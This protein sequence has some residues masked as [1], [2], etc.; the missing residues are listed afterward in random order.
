MV[1]YLT[2]IGYITQYVISIQEHRQS[3]LKI[4]SVNNICHPVDSFDLY[5]P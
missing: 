4:A 3:T 2:P 5:K 1:L